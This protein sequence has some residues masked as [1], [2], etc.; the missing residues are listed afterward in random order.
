MSRIIAS[1]KATLRNLG[2]RH[3]LI[4]LLVQVL[5]RAS[6]GWLRIIKYRLLVQPIRDGIGIP[7]HRGRGI[8]IREIEPEDKLLERMQHPAETIAARF[9]QG[10]R[11]LVALKQGELVGFLWWTE[12]AYQEDEVR[13]RFVP[14]PQGRS[15]WDFDVFVF[16]EHRFSPV[17]S[18]LWQV[19]SKL[20]FAHGIRV[21]CSRISAFNSGSFEAHRRLGARVVGT[22]WYLCIG[23][24]QASFAVQSPRFHV[25]FSPE[26]F[27]VVRVGS[28]QDSKP[29]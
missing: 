18:R 22:R 1:F 11:C 15:V 21:S 16:P 6:R 5:L 8:E 4:Y 7:E 24:M 26:S 25:S 9:R 19:A 20:L 3:G 28:D 17:F 13:C 23:S 2:W 12:G 10:A 27:P 14:E 29:S